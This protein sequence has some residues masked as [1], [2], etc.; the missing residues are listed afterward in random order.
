MTVV[1]SSILRVSWPGPR[2]TLGLGLWVAAGA[3]LA[4]S[5]SISST[6]LAFGA[7]Q[8]L[9]FAGKLTSA[10]VT[11]TARVEIFCTDIITGGTYTIS[12]GPGNYSGAD[13]GNFRYLS[14]GGT[15]Y[16]AYNFYTDVNHATIWGN[17]PGSLITGSIPTG[18]SNPS[19]TVYGK[20]PAGQNTLKSGSYS[21]TLTMT[22]TYN[23]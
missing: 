20:V 1:I 17:I 13:N 22:V 4:G 3:V 5:C 2:L 10:N 14:N 12:L 15:P 7:Y 21:D 6:G 16:M 11:S 18:T 23:P 9:N 19:H 8:P